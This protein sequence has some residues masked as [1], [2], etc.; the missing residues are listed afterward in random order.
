MDGDRKNIEDD[1]NHP[2]KDYCIFL[3][4]LNVKKIKKSK[5]GNFFII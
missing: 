3:C 5:L 4:P 1:E 2:D